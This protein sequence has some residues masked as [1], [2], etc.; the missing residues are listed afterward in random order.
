MIKFLVKRRKSISI[1]LITLQVAQLVTPT[2]SYALTSGPTQPEVHGFQPAGTS[3]MVD[4]FTGDFSYNIP[5]F[6]LPGPN[7][8]YPFNLSY[9]AGVGMDTEASWVGL[10]FN[11]NPGAINRQMRGLPDEFKGDSIFTKMA[12]D[13]N[14]TVGLSAGVNLE[15]FGADKSLGSTG[16]S[17]RFNNYKGFGYSIDGQVGYSQSVGGGMTAGVGLNLSLD[18]NEGISATPN[19]S[20]GTKLGTFGL[21]AGYNSNTGL[22]SVSLN[23]SLRAFGSKEIGKDGEGNAVMAP[24][25]TNQ[26]SV[27]HSSATL[28]LAHSGYTPMVSMPMRN[29]NLSARFNVG[30]AFGGIFG[31]GYFRGYY[32][33]QWLHNNKKRVPA[34]AY[35]Y[36]N[37]QDAATN[38]EAMLD[39]NR[40][41]DGV[42]SKESPNLPIPSL[43]YDI[44][45]VTG[46]GISAMYRPMRNDYGIIHDPLTLST[47]IGGA[48][49][50]DGAPAASHGGVNLNMNYST[51]TSGKWVT[52]NQMLQAGAF[53]SK[54]G[55]DTYEPV[56]FKV[57]GENTPLKSSS[58]EAL[59]GVEPVR[60][61]LTGNNANAEATNQ[62]ERKTWSNA[63]PDPAATDRERKTRAQVIQTITNGE[64][65]SGGQERI[66][67]FKVK[68]INQADSVVAFDRSGLKKHHI[69]AFTALTPEG[70]RY[71]YG[72]P[73][74]N[75]RQEDVSFSAAGL[76]NS[77]RVP[78]TT[79]SS[80]EGS[81][82]EVPC[83]QSG[84]PCYEHPGTEN[85]L[86]RVEM[87][88]YAHSYLL[89]SIIGPDYVDLTGDGVTEDDLGYWVKFTYKRTADK[90]NPYK[91]RDP[92]SKAH[93]QE[94]WKTDARD[95]KGSYVY[96]EKE[97]WYLAKA[98]TK[99]HIAT[100]S[101][102]D[103][104]DG[105]GVLKALQDQN[106]TGMAVK[107]LREIKLFTRA[108]GTT[109]PL[110]VVKFEY[111]YALCP[112]V[113]NSATQQG[114][115]TLRKVW[116]E[117]GNS[118]RGRF[119]P[120]VFSYHPNNPAYDQ[121]AY[122]RWGNYKPNPAGQP[123]YNVD[124]PYAEQDPALKAEVDANAAAWSLTE[125][126]LPSGGVIKVDYESDD[127]GYVQHLP[128]MQMMDMVSPNGAE[129]GEFKLTDESIIWFKL[130]KPIPGNTTPSA[131]QVI[132]KYLDKNRSMV[133]FKVKINLKDSD[134][135]AYE[136]ISAYAEI[137]FS[138]TQAMQLKKD[139][140]GDYA[141]GSFALVKEGGNNPLSRRAWQ[142]LRTNQPELVYAEKKIQGFKQVNSAKGRLEQ[143]RSLGN[144]ITPI[145]QFFK[146]GFYKA[147]EKDGWG[148]EV[149][150][151]KSWVRLNSPDKIKYGGG[152]RV[153]QVTMTDNWV[154]DKEGVYGQVY[155]YT[156]VEDNDT[157]SS[158][159]A[160]YEPLIGGEENAL[161]M[162]KKYVNSVPL[163]SDNNMFFE[164]PV[165]ESYYPGP[166]V[167]Y[168]KV[169][170]TSLAASKLAGIDIKNNE[171][172]GGRSVIPEK[173]T[174]ISYGTSGV[175]V[176]EFYTARD[177]PVIADE[178]EKKDKPFQLSVPVPLMG[179]IYAGK[180]TTTQG[181]SIV[182]NDMHGKP[183]QVS[184]YRQ[185]RQGIRE[186]EA[187]SWVKYNYFQ[188]AKQYQKVSVNVLTAAFK[189]NADGTLSIASK[190][191]Q[192]NKAIAKYTIGQE[193]E[194]FMDMREYADNS[195]E[196]GVS[197]NVDVIY[198]GPFT[199][200]AF[201]PWLSLGSNKQTLRSAVAN[202]VI[203]KAGILKSVEAYDGGSMVITENI[204]WDKATG[205]VILTRVNNNFDAPLYS[206]NIPAYT[207]YQGMGAA[208]QNIGLTFSIS[209][210]TRDDVNPSLYSFTPSVAAEELAP[211]DEILLYPTQSNWT[212]PLARIIYAGREDDENVLY[213]SDPLTA[214]NYRAMIVRSGYRNQLNVSAGS[215][216]AL[217]D[218]SKSGALKSYTKTISIPNE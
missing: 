121:H 146:G 95:D 184:T 13:P 194:F 115:L 112:G 33:E 24:D 106:H 10:G 204:K 89:T 38:P 120:Y 78:V 49:G 14:V 195:Q 183:K 15:V 52:K 43:T 84:D 4:L 142:H 8:G 1:F 19:L 66:P 28:S 64:L 17:V 148:R 44:Y 199:W 85:F 41:K 192:N 107:A 77:S 31:K 197:I 207:H 18:S 94:G 156:I 134:E 63:L 61:A 203:F 117:Y 202:K 124:F 187:I 159:V 119:N 133:F 3:D 118:R 186:P 189:D 161:R 26:M 135:N 72:I 136:Y 155:D 129:T 5:L 170:V 198:I 138:R 193:N 125:I 60:I 74:Y 176:H 152:L 32:S 178:T 7:G 137:D 105:R 190:T 67:Q 188:E 42:I 164:F 208:F 206:Y 116:F 62:L 86:K 46:Q 91:W 71:N 139:A 55:D 51:S 30:G 179:T 212:G 215:I 92:F 20:L 87:P 158:G 93:F 160:A 9:Q 73:A 214:K 217:E 59:G 102:D 25:A 130:E 191:E 45:S 196:G 35:G 101:L 11:L 144:V 171:L 150:A 53:Q 181:Y 216:T 147:C 65:V 39:F 123:L 169:T 27:G 163:R 23:H 54:R 175:T 57:H 140:N 58:L 79:G 12:I 209:Q 2:A 6:E 132:M 185:D 68:Y 218:P 211:G 113:Y 81:T 90:S 205:G 168:R 82:T 104:E 109:N 80:S 98:E 47:T 50:I 167:G 70:L 40:E 201:A 143:I 177:F 200:P 127:Y 157:I 151:G 122:D 172:P 210:V 69:A 126:K 37:Y 76:E 145:L 108:S 36:L 128:A 213:S 154:D 141:Y 75:L 180:L 166:Q 153:R 114:K 174:G 131:Q 34:A 16:L 99:S 173:G 103:R 162:A 48:V 56:Y 29:I 96:G 88:S 182:T 100:F 110:K 165:N 149:L 22:S 97:I 21:S 111:D 83:G